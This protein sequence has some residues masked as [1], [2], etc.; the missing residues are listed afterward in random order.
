MKNKR[1]IARLDIKNNALVKG[2]NMEGLRVIGSPSIIAQKYY[3]DGIDELYYM[4]VVASLYDR[5]GLVEF[6]NETARNVF[7]PLSVGGGIRTISD[8]DELLSAGAD[9][10]TVNTAAVKDV[11]FIEKIAHKFGSST[12]VCAIEVL[13]YEG[14]YLVFTDS[15]REFTGLTVKNW[16]REVQKAGVGELLVSSI[17]RDGT[18]KGIDFELMDLIKDFITVPLIAHGGIGKVSHI[19][20]ALNDDR[21]DGVCISSLLHYH[22]E[23]LAN[24]DTSVLGNRSFISSGTKNRLIEPAS[25]TEI[26][27]EINKAGYSLR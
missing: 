14:E 27:E 16:A 7:I 22:S 20:E 12:V 9:K 6:V 17:D 26:K 23:I 5:N 8:V 21:I 11:K 3:N 4:D 18:G 25:I 13:K 24:A 15:G 1:L 10:V 2:I 19:I